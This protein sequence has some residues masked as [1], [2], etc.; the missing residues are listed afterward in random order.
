MPQN[1]GIHSEGKTNLLLRHARF[2]QPLCGTLQLTFR[3]SLHSWALYSE[4]KIRE[5]NMQVQ[6][7]PLLTVV[8]IQAVKGR[9]PNPHL[10]VPQ[11]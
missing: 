4:H 10:M 5:N 6:E 1:G 8:L 9:P 2:Q 3:E 11:Y 7:M